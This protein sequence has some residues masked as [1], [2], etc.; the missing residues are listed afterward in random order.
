[1]CILPRLRE[2][3]C[4][5][6]PQIF[7]FHFHFFEVGGHKTIFPIKLILFS[8]IST[9]RSERKN[10]GLGTGGKVLQILVDG[11]KKATVRKTQDCFTPGLGLLACKA[12]C[13]CSYLAVIFFNH[14]LSPI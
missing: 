14:T 8:W 9:F 11:K 1:M 7:Q 13:L 2:N 12:F 3:L 5:V 10:G 4:E 6:N